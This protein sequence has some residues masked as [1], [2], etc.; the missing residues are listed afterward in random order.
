M[1]AL[2]CRSGCALHRLLL[3]HCPSSLQ[4]DVI[5]LCLRPAQASPRSQ[6]SRVALLRGP[7]TQV[8]GLSCQSGDHD[9][10]AGLPAPRASRSRGTRELREVC[11]RP[12][13]RM[14]C[15]RRKVR[16]RT[17]RSSPQPALWSRQEPF[18]S[19]PGIGSEA[20]TF[21]LASPLPGGGVRRRNGPPVAGFALRS[22]AADVGRPVWGRGCGSPWRWTSPCCSGRVSRP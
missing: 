11:A 22:P 16:P 14:V 17:A 12:G 6:R 20:G 4:P 9:K 15:G 18:F 2:F 10:G 1:Q 5:A 13:P 3:L 8:P 7:A 21:L 19:R